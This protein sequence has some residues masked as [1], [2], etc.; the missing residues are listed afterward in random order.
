MAEVT[1]KF[2]KGDDSFTK[3]EELRERISIETKSLSQ[4]DQAILDLSEIREIDYFFLDFIFKIDKQLQ[5]RGI[6]LRLRN[7]EGKLKTTGMTG[8]S[9]GRIKAFGELC[10]KP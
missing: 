2:I 1:I 6:T 7:C 9:Q 4:G 5:E 10:E 3:I 8:I